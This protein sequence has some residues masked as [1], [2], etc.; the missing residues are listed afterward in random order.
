MSRLKSS[1]HAGGCEIGY[2][3]GMSD[4]RNNSR[5]ASWLVG[6]L[7]LGASGGISAEEDAREPQV[8]VSE[9][10]KDASGFL[11][12][13]VSSPFQA[14]KTTIR[15]LLPDAVKAGEKYRVIYVLPVEAGLESRYGDGLAEVK[16]QDLHNK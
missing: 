2:G 11:N 13:R 9:G 4:T 15:V 5:F 14:G 10:S 3:R 12:H 1:Y 8:T 6:A 16:K 7:L